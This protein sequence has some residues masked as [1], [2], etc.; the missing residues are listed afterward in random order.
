MFQ[1]SKWL[2]RILLFGK[3][4][5]PRSLFE[6]L[7]PGYH[8]FLAWSAA[9][10]YMMPSKKL[11]VIGVTGT[12]GKSTVVY[13]LSRA[14]E[15]AGIAAAS[16]GSL[17]SGIN[18]KE[19]PN[20]FPN[21]MP[22]RWRLQ[23]FLKLAV[24][25][26]AR[27]AILEVTSEGIRQKRHLGVKFDTAVFTN[28]EPEHIERHGSF[29]NYYAAKQ[30]LFRKAKF[31]HVINFDDKHKNLFSG[32]AAEKKITFGILGGDIQ[33]REISY[34]DTGTEFR[35]GESVFR[36]KQLGEFNVYNALAVL[37]V[38]RAYDIPLGKIQDVFSKVNFIRGRLQEMDN[39]RGLR[40]FVDYAHTPN[41][42]SAV[43]K[44]TR[45]LLKKNHNEKKLICVL[46]AAGG[47]RDKRKRPEL[48]KLAG[49]YCDKIILTNEDPFDEDPDE[50]LADILSGIDRGKLSSVYKIPERREAI[51]KALNLAR[52][53][54]IIIMT[55]KGAESYMRFKD[56]KK[57]PWDEA[58]IVRELLE[59]QI[60]GL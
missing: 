27:Y 58:R 32:F 25:A 16:L 18:G 31:C 50:I 2:E 48:G 4:A 20:Y 33:A 24:K 35:V 49:I 7:Q 28:L 59:E 29:E 21:T 5:I 34:Q 15:E 22:G 8:W 3:K 45:K 9:V 10:F 56:G 23:K 53:G 6:T 55:G 54:D 26:G 19:W 13:L 1:E 44:T 40:I 46:G 37:A 52:R 39:V 42:L 12:K 36:S 11:K 51:K 41:A 60:N 57:I 38:M 43:Y 14:F 47:G 30:E 17:G